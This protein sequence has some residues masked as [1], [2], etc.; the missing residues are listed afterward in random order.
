[1]RGSKVEVSPGVWRLR[2]YAGRKVN[3]TPI[4]VTKTVRAPDRRRGAGTRMADAEL[5]KMLS[6]VEAGH[7]TSTTETVSSL[8]DQWFEHLEA[9][10]RSPT[11]LRKYRS[12]ADT[13]VRPE[14]GHVKLNKLTARQLDALY[15]KLTVKGRKP[16]T[17]RR[18]HALLSAALHQAERWDLVDRSVARR[19]TP[20][21]IH[22]EQVETPTPEDVRALVA[23]A[24]ELE[25]PGLAA[26]LLLAALTGARRGELCALRWND[27]DWEQGVVR[28]A[29][30]VYETEG[31]GWDEKPTKTHQARRI[32]LDALGLEVLQRHRAACEELAKSLDL[33]IPAD[34]FVFSRSPQGTQ[35]LRPDL[36]SKFTVR[37]AKKAGVDTHLHALRHF[38]ATQLIAGGHDVRT[39][40][41][42]LGHADAS[43]T[44]R[45]YSHVLPERD[46][47]AAAALGR[48]LG[49]A[50]AGRSGPRT[51]PRGRIPRHAG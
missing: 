10:G 32:G 23:A 40:A 22:A 46:R 42:R 50:A 29:R 30:S 13:V 48:V 18:V 39:V 11:T 43:I 26:M 15:A 17:V 31:G 24:E 45:V 28:I 41:G 4:Q 14:F 20:P 6:A 19:A 7:V 8:L 25:E 44:L 49:P 38:S 34:A 16:T 33:E 5:A 27:I 35:P 3:G 21:P 1:M 37:A 51:R 9:I 36:V 2:V 47:E 12:I